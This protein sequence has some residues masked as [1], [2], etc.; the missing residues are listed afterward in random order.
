MRRRELI[1]ALAGLGVAA[2]GPAP[3][4]HTVV[5][6]AMKFAPPPA[7]FRVGDVVVWDNRDMF[8]HTATARNGAFDVDLPAGAR[9]ETILEKAGDIAF[10]CRFHPGMT[11]VLKVAS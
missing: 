6:D 10:F 9:R 11:G 7:G 8:R 5:L 1:L 3:R 2:A 4:R